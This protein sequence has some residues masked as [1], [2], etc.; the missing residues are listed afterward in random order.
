[1]TSITDVLRKSLYYLKKKKKKKKVALHITIWPVPQ[2]IGKLWP[3]LTL[4]Y[5]IFVFASLIKALSSSDLYQ[6]VLQQAVDTLNRNINTC[7]VSV[8]P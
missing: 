3:L 6:L 8:R 4:R 2:E 1:M 5:F 7:F